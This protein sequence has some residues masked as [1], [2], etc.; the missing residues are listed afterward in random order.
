[1][2]INN[3]PVSRQ[4]DVVRE[5]GPLSQRD[6]SSVTSVALATEPQF[7]H[8][9]HEVEDSAHLQGIWATTPELVSSLHPGV[10]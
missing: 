2:K 5:G 8:L 7:P 6:L 1:M 3:R 4:H 9:L 10:F